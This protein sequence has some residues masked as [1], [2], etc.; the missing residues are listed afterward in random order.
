[1]TTA[2]ITVYATAMV[3]CALATSASVTLTIV[4]VDAE[5]LLATVESTS[6]LKPVMPKPALIAQPAETPK[7]AHQSPTE[8][9]MP[10]TPITLLN[11]PNLA[12]TNVT[13]NVPAHVLSDT[14]ITIVNSS[15]TLGIGADRKVTLGNS[16][17]PLS[18]QSRTRLQP[19]FPLSPPRPF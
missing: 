14:D 2:R 1:M 8:N 10:T 19:R 18:P 15:T 16:N 17:P 3:A 5:G 6:S 7:T 12:G 13:P 9:K 4:A 11:L